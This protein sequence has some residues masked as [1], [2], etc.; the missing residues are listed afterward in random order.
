MPLA[1]IRVLDLTRLLPGPYCS[2]LLADFGAEVIKVE[3]TDTGDYMRKF[4]PMIDEDSALFHSLNLNKKSICLDLKSEE[5]QMNFLRL[6]EGADVV[7]ESFRPGVMERLGIGYEKLKSINPGIIYCSITGYGQTGPNAAEP[8]H[9]I[10]YLSIAGLLDLMGGKDG[11]PIIPAAQIAD[12]G[13]GAL[14]AT[15][16]ILLALFEREQSGRGQFVDIAMLDGVISW[17]QTILP[18][19]LSGNTQPKRGEQQLDGGRAC[20]A[21]YETKDSRYMSVGALEPKF[22]K[23]FCNVIGRQDFIPLIEA[24]LHEQYRLKYEIQ[25]IMSQKTQRE[26]IAEFANVEACVT[27]LLTLEEMIR[28]P[29]VMAREMILRSTLPD[30]GEIRRIGIPIK[31]S[32]TPGSFVSHAPKLGAHTQEILKELKQQK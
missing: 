27:P 21:V 5:G 14:P 12:I 16:G 11:K 23:G 4:E 18:G 29:Q 25:M 31:L 32:E 1:S 26:W 30:F 20:Y 22:W 2:M 8:G 10:N 3:A 7:V 15:V 24:P 17:L 28:N 19:V 13:G 9:D 6:A